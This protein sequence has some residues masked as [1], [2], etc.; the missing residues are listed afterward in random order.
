VIGVP[1]ASVTNYAELDSTLDEVLVLPDS[2]LEEL[3]RKGMT[4]ALKWR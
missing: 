4:R 3:S 2:A 1:T